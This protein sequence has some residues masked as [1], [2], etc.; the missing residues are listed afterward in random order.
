MSGTQ[1]VAMILLDD[2]DAPSEFSQVTMAVLG[3]FPSSQFAQE[4]GE[5]CIERLNDAEGDGPRSWGLDVQQIAQSYTVV[6]D[7]RGRVLIDADATP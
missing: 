4:V 7:S 5:R 2:D 6:K 1:W 3:P